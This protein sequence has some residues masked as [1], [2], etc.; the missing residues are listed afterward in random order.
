MVMIFRF[1][2]MNKFNHFFRQL[3]SHPGLIWKFGAGFIFMA[4]GLVLLLLPRLTY[5]L[6]EGTRY[7]FT[8][9]LILYGFFR[10]VTFYIEFKN[11]ED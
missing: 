2:A 11:L 3:Y 10:M 5:G 6:E 4:M 7:G 8:A 9:L 1:K